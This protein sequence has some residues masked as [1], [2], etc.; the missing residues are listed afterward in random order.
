MTIVDLVVIVGDVLDTS[1]GAARPIGVEV[2]FAS[3]SEAVIG[4]VEGSA[5]C[6]Y[7]G[8]PFQPIERVECFG[9]HFEVCS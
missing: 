9:S 6:G 7:L 8:P 2:I 4:I 3:T 1:S 5:S